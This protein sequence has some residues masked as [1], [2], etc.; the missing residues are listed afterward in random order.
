[1]ARLLFLLLLLTTIRFDVRGA[2]KDE[3][4]VIRRTVRGFDY[5][6]ERYI[7]PQHYNFTAMAQAGYTYDYYTLRSGDGQILNFAPDRTFKAGPYFGWKW[8]FAGWMFSL[9]HSDFSKNKT[10][11]DLSIYSSQI[12]IDFF[13]RRTGNDYKIRNAH[14][15]KNIDTAPIDHLPFDGI[16]VGI[17]GGNIYYVFNHGRFSYPAAFAQSTIQKISCGSWLA[18][19][20]YSINSLDF[21]YEKMQEVID[22]R[23]DHTHN[24][25]LDSGLMFRSAHYQDFNVSVGYAYNWVFAKNFLIGGCGQMAV[26]YKNSSGET[27]SADD[28]YSFN[29]VSPNFIGR[30]ALVYNNM[31]WYAGMSAIVR[32]NFYINSRFTSNNTFGSIN[33]YAGFNFGLKKRYRTKKD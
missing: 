14:L 25:K 26:S 4:G 24:V 6:D 13:Y 32:S 30:F 7:E 9:G 18:G 15:G 27:I 11:I 16:N 10:D 21:D 3:L 17:T 23:I 29:N 8:F 20:G 19:I 28:I 31:R 33:L 12:G 22:E 5:I 2:D 1:M